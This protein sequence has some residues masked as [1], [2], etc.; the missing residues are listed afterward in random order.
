MKKRYLETAAWVV[1]LRITD[2]LLTRIYTPNLASEWNPIVSRLG[3]SWPGFIAVQILI[4][5]TVIILGWFYFYGKRPEVNLKGLNFSDFV[6]CFF[7]GK[8][9]PWP[10]RL[11]SLPRNA[12]PHLIFNGFVL[13]AVSIGISLFAIANNLLLIFD[14]DWYWRFLEKSHNLFFPVVILLIVYAA[15]MAF[16][17]KEYCGYLEKGRPA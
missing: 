13:I 9:K 11:F 3:A 15:A 12:G 6:Y 10:R 4:T 14:A 8:L 1:L 7:Y 5:G 17:W 2:L 16:F